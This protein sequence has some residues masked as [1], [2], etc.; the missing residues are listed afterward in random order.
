MNFNELVRI[1]ESSID[2]ARNHFSSDVFVDFKNKKPRLKPEISAQIKY[3]VTKFNEIVPVK[4]FFIKGSILTK[5]YGPKADIDVY[6]M[7][8]V[9]DKESVKKK[10]EKLWD[11][12]DGTLAFGTKYPLQY[13][14][15]EVDYDFDKTEAAYDVQKDRWIKQTDPKDINV[16]NYRK[17]LED[18]LNKMDLQTG[19]LKRDVLDYE[20]L[21]DIPERDLKKLKKLLDDKLKEINYDITILLKSYDEIKTARNDAFEKDMTDK[22]LEKFGRKTHLPGNVIFK[23]LERY[24][25]IQLVRNIKDIIGDDEKAQP[26]EVEKIKNAMFKEGACGDPCARRQ[27][28]GFTGM[29]RL[30]QNMMPDMHKADPTEIIQVKNIKDGKTNNTPV[31]GIVL[32]RII[33]KY[34]I[35]DLSETKPR[36]LGNTGIT[37][38]WCNNN[39]CYVL[40]K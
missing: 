8:D 3:H 20:H 6:I 23:F 33:K 14:I 1:M 35:G 10:I 5:Q 29:G 11:K 40:R 36:K 32:Q 16:A 39:K 4:K 24:Y 2:Y 18:V 37:I 21:V 34:N 28:V 26:D 31:R 38:M 30:H 7:A 12:L 15:S 27:Q 22:E 9:P 17:D 13:Y 25:Y 19:E